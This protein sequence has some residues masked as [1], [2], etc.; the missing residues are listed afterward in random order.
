MIRE[1][2]D[3]ILQL[4]KPPTFKDAEG[5]ERY[6][7]SGK[8]LGFPLEPGFNGTSLEAAVQSCNPSFDGSTFIECAY[9]GVIVRQVRCYNSHACSQELFVCR[10]ILPNDFSFGSYMDPEMFI[11]RSAD[12]FER[13]D[14]YKAM[15]ALVSSVTEVSESAVDDDGMSQTVTFKN[16]VGRKNAGIVEPFVKLRAYRT[17]R[18]VEQ[19]EVTYL[20]RFKKGPSVALFEASG[21]EWKIQATDAIYQYIKER[22]GDEVTVLR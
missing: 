16:R 22:V 1:A 4:Q 3:R 5:I 15:I 19:P 18:E 8:A 12:F 10:P 14:N 13:N 7:D 6:T 11:I 21:Y 20:L 2:I 17:F 9:D